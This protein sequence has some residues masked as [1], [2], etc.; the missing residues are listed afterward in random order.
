MDSG[1]LT[2][3]ASRKNFSRRAY[4]SDREEGQSAL[5]FERMASNG[6]IRNL[7]FGLKIPMT[8]MASVLEL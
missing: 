2:R 4:E 5:V 1:Q 6:E 7:E 8:S 3:E